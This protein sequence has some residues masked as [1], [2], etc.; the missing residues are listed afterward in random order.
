MSQYA[1]ALILPCTESKGASQNPIEK[2]H[3]LSSPKLTV[4]TMHSG[5]NVISRDQLMQALYH[6][7]Q[8]DC[9]LECV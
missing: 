8:W 1:I 4:S 5:I 9:E 7:S 2:P 6:T 3:Y